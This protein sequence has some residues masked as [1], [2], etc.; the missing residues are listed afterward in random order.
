MI[1]WEF[2]FW[3]NEP[4]KTHV[5]RVCDRALF[6]I[7]WEG[8]GNLC[9]RHSIDWM[10]DDYKSDVEYWK[11]YDG[12]LECAEPDCMNRGDFMTHVGRVCRECL[13][14]GYAGDAR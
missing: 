13:I 12:I 8:Q 5:C 10:L 1:N 9:L 11:T 2:D 4:E 3:V 6:V 14:D 7:E